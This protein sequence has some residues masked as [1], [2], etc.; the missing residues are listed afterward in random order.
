AQSR[1]RRCHMLWSVPGHRARPRRRNIL[2]PFAESLERRQVPALLGIPAAVT[3]VLEAEPNDTVDLA[4]PL[5]DLSISPMAGA[6]GTIGDGPAGAADVDWYHFALD[7]PASV[8]LV[9]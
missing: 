4:Q 5:G 7:A 3:P 8:T 9:A 2:G 6:Q 1:S